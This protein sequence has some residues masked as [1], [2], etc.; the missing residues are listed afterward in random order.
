MHDL[1][2]FGRILCSCPPISV[3]ALGR[4]PSTPSCVLGL[5]APVT[6]SS[7][8]ILP[9][10]SSCSCLLPPIPFL[11]SRPHSWSLAPASACMPAACPPT[12][13]PQ[14]QLPPPAALLLLLLLLSWLWW[15]LQ[16]AAA[17]GVKRLPLPPS[18]LLARLL[19][20]CRPPQSPPARAAPRPP[21]AEAAAG[22]QQQQ[23]APGLRAQPALQQTT[24]TV[25]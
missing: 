13:S 9:C 19:P 23:L 17:V 10:H 15:P 4:S 21:P 3:E 5:K 12:S 25:H 6:L 2:C 8:C 11:S 18:T 14:L 20:P 7:S 16:P 1:C 22:L 24:S